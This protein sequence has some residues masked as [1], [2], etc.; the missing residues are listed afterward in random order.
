MINCLI[1]YM[2]LQILCL[3]EV[4]ELTQYLTNKFV[5]HGHL[6]NKGITFF[7]LNYF[8]KAIKF[9]LHNCFFSIGNIIMIQVIGRPLGS[10]PAPFFAN[11]FQ[12]TKK[13]TG[14]RHN[15]NLEQS[16]FEKAVISLTCDHQ[17]MTVPLRNIVRI[18]IR[19]NYN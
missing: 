6:R 10:D 13:L 3:K 16:M 14:L 19:Q 9:L 7:L 5:H 1:F 11:S 2:K 12:P 15:V 8:L 18:F 17:L 4:L